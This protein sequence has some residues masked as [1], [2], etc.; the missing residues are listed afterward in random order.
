MFSATGSPA[1]AALSYQKAALLKSFGA[2]SPAKYRKGVKSHD[3]VSEYDLGLL[4]S[5][6]PGHAHDVTKAVSFLR[7]SSD[8][9]YV[10]AMH[11]LAVL[12]LHHPPLARR[13]GEAE[14]LLEDAESSGYWRSSM[15]LGVLAW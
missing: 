14:K 6:E 13:G 11:S 9:G 4:Y 5:T 8:S 12:V 1:A 2:P 10:P 7:A 3:T 15:V